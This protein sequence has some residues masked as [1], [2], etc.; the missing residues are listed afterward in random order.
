MHKQM[1]AIHHT[2]LKA[3]KKSK[4]TPED[5]YYVWKIQIKTVEQPAKEY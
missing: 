3:A 1:T 2:F 4:V 5:C